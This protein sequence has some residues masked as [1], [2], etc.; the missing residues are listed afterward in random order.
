MGYYDWLNDL[1]VGDAVVVSVGHSGEA[2]RSIERTTATQF[3]VDGERYRRNDG[4]QVGETGFHI[5]RLLR[6]PTA[7][8]R[9]ACRRRLAVKRLVRFADT[10]QRNNDVPLETL[11]AMAALIPARKDGD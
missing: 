2:I 7:E 11:E 10:I 9:I 4:R 6:R 5:P 1:K 3:I 8:D